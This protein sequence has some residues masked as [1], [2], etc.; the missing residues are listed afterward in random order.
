[1]F[2]GVSGTV[3][4][5]EMNEQQREQFAE[6]LRRE[7]RTRFVGKAKAAYTAAGVNSATW[8]RAVN[9]LPMKDHSVIQIVSSLWPDT[10]GDWTQIPDAGADVGGDVHPE[11][12]YVASTQGEQVH[13]DR[14]T[15]DTDVLRAITAMSATLDQLLAGQRDLEARISSLEK[16]RGK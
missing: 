12:Q 10:Q 8:S 4:G 7:Q 15:E 11:R 14:S 16:G 2:L 6:R 13:G 9:A 3:R 5:V 1:M